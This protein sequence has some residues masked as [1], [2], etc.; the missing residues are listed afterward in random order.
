[1]VCVYSFDGGDTLD[2]VFLGSYLRETVL[3]QFEI[4][5]NDDPFSVSSHTQHTDSHTWNEHI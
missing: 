1:M 5:E 3:D 4:A 2:S